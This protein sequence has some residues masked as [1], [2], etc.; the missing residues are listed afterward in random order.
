MAQDRFVDRENMA[1]IQQPIIY[2]QIGWQK[3]VACSDYKRIP[4]RMWLGHHRN[5][6]DDFIQCPEC[7]GT[8]QVPRYQV[9]DARTGQEI[10]YESYG[11]DENGNVTFNEKQKHEKETS[12]PENTH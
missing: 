11:R 6:V 1:T 10:D 3:C 2:R 5:G 9:L 7:K 4:G 8:G 12:W